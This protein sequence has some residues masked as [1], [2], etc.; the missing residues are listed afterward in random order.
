MHRGNTLLRTY[1]KTTFEN[2]NTS[3]QKLKK[4][5]PGNVMKS[6]ELISF[7]RHKPKFKTY[8]HD[9]EFVFLLLDKGNT[10]VCG[11]FGKLLYIL[12][13]LCMRNST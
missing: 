13:P 10:A 11:A 8:L 7:W 3:A 12:E 5:V 6:H 1:Q 2:H 9:D 4:T